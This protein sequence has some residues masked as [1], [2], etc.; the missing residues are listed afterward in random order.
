MYYIDMYFS[1]Y[2]LRV[3]IF[4]STMHFSGNDGKSE[5]SSII[6]TRTKEWTYLHK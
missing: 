6:D 4:S 5:I 2:N 3:V 1:F